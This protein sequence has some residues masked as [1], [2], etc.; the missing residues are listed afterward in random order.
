MQQLQH[1]MKRIS[2]EPDNTA[3][4]DSAKDPPTGNSDQETQELPEA[5]LSGQSNDVQSTESADFAQVAQDTESEQ[6][7]E[8]GSQE[9]S[10]NSGAQVEAVDVSTD[11]S[12]SNALA[13]DSPITH[14]SQ[15]NALD[16]SIDSDQHL[17]VV[18][19]MPAGELVLNEQT[20]AEYDVTEAVSPRQGFVKR[21]I[22]RAVSWVKRLINFGRKL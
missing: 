22:Q 2:A 16:N 4:D 21:W 17:A 7:S 1:M 13:V 11:N 6:R 8:A 18:N 9:T 12:P 19:Q 10:L 3:I 5:G 20:P 14:E 15:P